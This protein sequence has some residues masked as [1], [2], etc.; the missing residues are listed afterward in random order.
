MQ[1]IRT[2]NPQS[3]PQHIPSIKQREYDDNPMTCCARMHRRSFEGAGCVDFSVGA[4]IEHSPR[5]HRWHDRTMR[6]IERHE[7]EVGQKATEK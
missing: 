2:G 1:H 4:R 7:R 3:Y 6:H 5:G